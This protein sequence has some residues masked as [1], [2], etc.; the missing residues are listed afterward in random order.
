MKVLRPLFTCVPP[1]TEFLGPAR[2]RALRCWQLVRGAFRRSDIRQSSLSD[3]GPTHRGSNTHRT[4]C[5]A[6]VRDGLTV[7]R[8]VLDSKG[9][10]E[11]SHCENLWRRGSELYP[12]KADEEIYGTRYAN[13]QPMQRIR[14]RV[15]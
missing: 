2:V 13:C 4:Y 15:I 10:R 3:G 7:W 11:V 1:E 6:P 5:R 14:L 8:D 9:C 12:M